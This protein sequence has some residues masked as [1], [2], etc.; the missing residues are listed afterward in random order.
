MSVCLLFLREKMCNIHMILV[1]FCEIFHDFGFGS[2]K[3][4]LCVILFLVHKISLN[5]VHHELSIKFAYISSR[6]FT[7]ILFK[8]D[9]F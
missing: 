6:Y 2:A 9:R 8:L 5:N 4:L 3:L 1:D 7:F